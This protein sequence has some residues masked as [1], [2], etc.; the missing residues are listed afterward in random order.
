MSWGFS[1]KIVLC[2]KEQNHEVFVAKDH[3]MRI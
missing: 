3:D 1:H 2:E